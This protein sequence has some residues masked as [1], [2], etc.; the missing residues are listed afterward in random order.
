MLKDHTESEAGSSLLEVAYAQIR[1][2]DLASAQ[3]TL[4]KGLSLEFENDDVVTSLKFV[5]FW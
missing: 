1:K 5:N 4:E 2:H 3:L